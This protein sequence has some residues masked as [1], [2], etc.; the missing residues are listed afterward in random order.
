M[1]AGRGDTQ[2]DLKAAGSR[3]DA[4]D[5]LW[6]R[7][8]ACLFFLAACVP[9]ETPTFGRSSSPD[10]GHYDLLVDQQGPLCAI[11]ELLDRGDL[12]LGQIGVSFEDG[13]RLMLR[14]EAA[15]QTWSCQHEHRS[16]FGC[17]AELEVLK[18]GVDVRLRLSLSLEG[19]FSTVDSASAR[20]SATLFC[21]GG[22]CS[23]EAVSLGVDD[24]PCKVEA[25]IVA[26]RWEPDLGY[27]VSHS[28]TTLPEDEVEDTGD[29]GDTGAP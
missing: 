14:D 5:V 16:L 20:F 27:S 1:T 18:E 6:L 4:R 28:D 23:E 8:G 19:A 12:P 17:G 21:D 11:P 3:S 9:L 7:T 25:S 10:E 15:A 22:G 29:T 13:G 2:D 26:T 24:F